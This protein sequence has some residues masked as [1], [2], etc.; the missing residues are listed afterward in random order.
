MPH[1]ELQIETS[2]GHCPTHVYHPSGHG[3][4]P[5]VIMYMDGIGMRPALMEVAERIANSGYYVM[6]PNLFYRVPFDASHGMKVFTDPD[7]RKD[8]MTRVMPSASPANIMRDT[9]A[10][11]AHLAARPDVRDDRIG[12]TGYCMGGRLAVYAAGHFGDRIAAA[13]S[14]HGSGLATDAP[15]SPHRL[16]PHMKA[17]VY[18]AG[19]IKDPGFD[20]AQKAR[21]EQALTDAGVDHTVE[22]YNAMHGFVPRDTP[23]HD[24][25]ATAKHWETLL[26]LF[27]ATLKAGPPQ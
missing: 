10:L 1:T 12:I 13:A 7:L 3:P 4:W 15:E 26:A 21:L 18:V 23:V 2:D 19:A 14:Y 9:E 27:A 11:F 5:G 16:A 20:D 24:E 8:L 25:A 6:L 22:T 17:R